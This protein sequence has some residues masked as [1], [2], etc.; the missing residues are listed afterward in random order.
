MSDV[1]LLSSDY[2]L[3]AHQ[4][5]QN[6]KEEV[7][8][9][10]RSVIKSKGVWSQTSAKQ[11]DIKQH[12]V[13]VKKKHFEIEESLSREWKELNNEL[14]CVNNQYNCATNNR[15]QFSGGVAE[16]VWSKE[17]P[18]DGLRQKMADEFEAFDKHFMEQLETLKE[19]YESSPL[20][21]K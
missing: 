19:R 18:S 9:L 1:Y 14:Q 11:F 12:I 13:S 2:R 5:G 8:L 10:N 17:C 20:K 21:Y 7:K 4:Y 3:N 6:L 16:W 15:E